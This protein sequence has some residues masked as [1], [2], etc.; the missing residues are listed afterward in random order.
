MGLVLGPL[1][2]KALV[3]TSAIG[4]GSLMILFTRPLSLAIL[5]LAVVLFAGP[6]VLARVVRRS[7]RPSA[8]QPR[9]TETSRR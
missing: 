7:P 5:V 6:L 4:D 3:Q 1:L 2:E 8:E 9:E